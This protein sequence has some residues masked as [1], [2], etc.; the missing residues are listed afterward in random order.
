MTRTA[1]AN[2]NSIF[3]QAL[4]AGTAGAI[5]FGLYQWVTT[6]LPSHESMVAMWQWVASGA[7]GAVALSNPAFA[8]LGVLVHLFVSVAWAG[9]YAYLASTQLFINQRW[10][11][12]GVFYGLMVYVFMQLLMLGA[13][14][15]AI[16]T[17][18][19]A[20]NSVI[21]Y[22]VFFGLPVAFV[23]AKTARA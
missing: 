10:P 20:L 3:K 17:P 21:A 11:I 15:L 1:P 16:P 6:V 14:L 8:W 23:V 18:L 19:E 7:I 13:H 9:G 5:G 22:C 4:L 12:S 2:W